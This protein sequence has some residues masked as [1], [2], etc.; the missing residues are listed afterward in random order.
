MNKRYL[1]S[2]TIMSLLCMLLSVNSIIAQKTSLSRVHENVRET[3]YPQKIHSIYINP[4]PLIIPEKMKTDDFVQFELSMD[5]T[6]PQNTTITAE[7]KPW[8]MFNPHQILKKG[9]WYWR[10]RNVSAKGEKRE[11]SET[12]EFTVSGDEPQFVTPS[13]DVFIRIC[14]KGILVCTVFLKKT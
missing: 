13:F 2:K 7:P 5:S 4:A 9:K 12:F 1:F 8:L 10:V 6:F 14:P 3:P 11:W